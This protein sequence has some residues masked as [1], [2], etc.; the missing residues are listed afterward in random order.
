M[1]ESRE[2]EFQSLV[3]HL[4]GELV[5]F[6]DVKEAKDSIYFT[7]AGHRYR[8]FGHKIVHHDSVLFKNTFTDFLAHRDGSPEG[9]EEN[10]KMHKEIDAELD[11]WDKYGDEVLEIAIVQAVTILKSKG[12]DEFVKFLKDHFFITTEDEGKRL[13]KFVKENA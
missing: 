7:L 13:L 9:M 8:T 12:R 3:K 2:V 10:K 5:A 11:D 6:T 1:S 4:S